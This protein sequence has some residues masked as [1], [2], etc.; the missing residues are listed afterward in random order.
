[1]I[2]IM[3]L[4]L[5]IVLSAGLVFAASALV[6]MALPHH[7]TDWKALA[8][9]DALRAALK[10][11]APGLYRMPFGEMN[12]PAFQKK[13]QEGPVAH[14]TVI[15]AS[16]ATAMGP[17]MLKSFVFNVIVSAGVA[18]LASRTLQ[19]GA[20]YLSVFRVAGTAAWFAYGFGVIPD[21]IWFGK[22]WSLTVKHLGD[23]LLYAL[24]TAGVFGWL[25]PAM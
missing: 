9:E 5:P 10:G 18:Y 8:N 4:W 16:A 2:P 11:A 14:L 7:K 3:S 23:A 1:M 15:P 12:D 20:E 13:L 17:M 24:L 21:S 22:P 6:W 19:P 25:W